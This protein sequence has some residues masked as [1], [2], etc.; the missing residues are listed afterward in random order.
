M[1]TYTFDP[2]RGTYV[3]SDTGTYIL[4]DYGTYILSADQSSGV[5]TDQPDYSPGSTVQI[6]ATFAP[7]ST[8]Q[9]TVAHDIGAGAD[10]I[11]GT[12]DDVLSNDLTGTGL[13]WTVTADAYGV[14]NTSWLVNQ[15]ALGQA[16]EL[17]AIDQTAG[18]MATTIFTD[19]PVPEPN[20]FGYID[21]HI[22]L[23]AGTGA[24]R[25]TDTALV[26]GAIWANVG[27][28]QD[29]QTTSSGTGI[30]HTA[31]QVE[32]NGSEQAFNTT[33]NTVLDEKF[34]NVHNHQLHLTNLFAVYSDGSPVTVPTGAPTYYEFKLDINQISSKPYLSLDGLQIWQSRT[35][36][37]GSGF[38]AGP[39]T[40][41]SPPSFAFDSGV[42]TKVYDLNSATNETGG[43]P[44]SVLLDSAF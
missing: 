42:A 2:T 22:E 43:I 13:T 15:D 26:A 10:G 11:W 41:G 33:V 24:T 28:P 9:F 1:A 30:Y 16:F 18:L 4:S 14:I 7:L 23:A 20:V 34:S 6:T 37:L 36:N 19:A 17:V 38:T 32:N 35:D 8:V 29:A 12:A 21:T 3:P 39:D 44:N 40:S 5:A 31:L 27:T 25:G